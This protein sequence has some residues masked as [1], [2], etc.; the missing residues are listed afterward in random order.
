MKRLNT[1]ITLFVLCVV[2]AF[3]QNAKYVFYFIGDGMGVNQVLGAEYYRR[4]VMG[5]LGIKPL[6]FPTFPHTTVA[7]T[8]SAS[9]DVTDSAASGTALA[10][11]H[12]TLNGTLGLLPDLETPVS[13]VA[14]WARE[15]G[16]RVGVCTSVSVDHA[17][18]AAFYAHVPKRNM[19]YKIGHQLPESGFDFFGGSEFKDPYG[20]KA[21]VKGEDVYTACGKAGYTIARGYKDYNKK[22]Q[23]AEKMILIQEEGKSRSSL[24]YAIDRTKKDLKL[25]DITRAGINF[26]M[27]EPEKGFFFMV[28]G[29]MIDWACHSNDG[30]TAFHEIEDMDEAIKVAY[31]FYC[32]HPDETLIVIT[33]DHETGGLVLTRGNYELNFGA[34]KYQKVSEHKYTSVIKDL[35]KKYNNHIPWKVMKKS[36]MKNFG[37]WDKLKLTADQEARIKA[38]YE[39]TL[40]GQDPKMIKSEYR[41][42]EPMSTMA[43]KVINE[44]AMASWATGDHSAGYVP[45]IA[46]GAGADKFDARTDNAEIPVKIAEAAGY[47]RD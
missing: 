29:G 46:I 47:K 26:L 18:P 5:E 30:A 37:F 45:V 4:A 16:K 43:K 21:G 17:T 33:A 39:K 44:I 32:Q 3:G 24:P 9:S 23:K 12:K 36:L 13:S 27:K 22:A 38:V 14:V 15:S 6:L 20:K 7:T 40:T 42:D 11:G 25:A 31:E 10:C 8:Y 41:R 28:E 34:F 2:M 35:R 19:Y 1:F